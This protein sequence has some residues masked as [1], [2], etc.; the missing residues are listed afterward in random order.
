MKVVNME[1]LEVYAPRDHLKMLNGRLIGENVGAKQV[2]VTF[3]VAESGGNA[4]MHS[5]PNLEKTYFAIEGELRVKG[6][7]EDVAVR[8]GMALFIPAGEAH[9]TYNLGPGKAEY[10]VINTT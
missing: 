2:R 1:E 9:L 10:L 6:E 8:K 7:K 5:H 3:G 4:T